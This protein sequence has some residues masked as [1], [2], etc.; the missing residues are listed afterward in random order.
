MRLERTRLLIEY[1][2]AHP[3]CDCGETDPVV[4]EFDHLRDKAFEITAKLVTYRW[5]RILDEIDKCEVVCANCHRRRTA[6]RRGA[7]RVVLTDRVIG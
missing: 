3:C 6:K 5:Q 7:L 4:L 1:F 2:K